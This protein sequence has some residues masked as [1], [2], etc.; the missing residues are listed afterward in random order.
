MLAAENPWLEGYSL[1]EHD[2]PHTDIPGLAP[3]WIYP[4]QHR[5]IRDVMPYQLS[6]DTAKLKRTHE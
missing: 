5:V 3:D 2:A 1:A 6:V 4:G